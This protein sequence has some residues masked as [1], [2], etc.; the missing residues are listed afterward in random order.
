M[1]ERNLCHLGYRF[2]RFRN[3]IDA[4]PALHRIHCPVLVLVTCATSVFLH[5]QSKLISDRIPNA[6][7]KEL[8]QA[9]LTEDGS[10]SEELRQILREFLQVPV[11]RPQKALG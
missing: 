9:H 3:P 6:W 1:R 11:K 10:F 5:E 7:W 2:A 4:R 8:E